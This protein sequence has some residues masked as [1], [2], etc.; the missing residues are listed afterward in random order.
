[1]NTTLC[2]PS[3]IPQP[4]SVSAQAPKQ[5]QTMFTNAV[6]LLE[7]TWSYQ[8]LPVQSKK[9]KNLILSNAC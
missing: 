8:R 7:A 9:K 6:A 1:M 5:M 2:F 4:V 3:L